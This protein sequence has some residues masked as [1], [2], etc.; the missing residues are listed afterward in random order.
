[1]SLP[2]SISPSAAMPLLVVG[3]GLTGWSVVR[4]LVAAGKEVEVTDSR[5]NPPYLAQLQLEYPQ[6]RFIPKIDELDFSSYEQIIASPGIA[7]DGDNI[8]GD[9]ELFAQEVQEPV[10]V[11]TGTNGKSTVTMLVTKML[12]AGGYVVHM[13]G[14]IGVPAL[15][16]LL[17]PQ[18][19]FY[20]LETSSFQLETTSSLS[21]ASAVVLNISEDHLD[22]Y[23]DIDDYANAKFRLYE[24]T[25]TCV[26]NRDDERV[27][28][29]SQRPGAI[30]FG[31]DA[32]CDDAFGLVENGGKQFVAFGENHLFDASELKLPGQQNVSNVLAAM[33]LIVG[34]GVT[35]SEEMIA[36]GKSYQGLPHRCERVGTWDGVTWINDSKGTNVGATL[37]AVKGCDKPSILIAGG[38]GKGADFHALAQG[39]D[40]GVKKVI[41]FGEDGPKICE[42]LLVAGV[43]KDKI[44]QGDDLQQ[45]IALAASSVAPGDTVLFSPACAS[46]D[47]FKNFEQR[48]EAFAQLVLERHHAS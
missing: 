44:Q 26:I 18:P 34:A 48:G 35:I 2:L 14:N 47:Q 19:D 29:Y 27:V 15:D 30:S 24:Q 39:I 4:H 33:A 37:A 9:I 32:P 13:G 17:L 28:A 1:M 23:V 16:L 31:L 3:L 38:Q 45:A 5:D 41:L 25:K 20:V 12:Q 7:I 42:A 6:V 11:I 43:Q 36:A 8:I 46:F 10:I 21:A 40:G 22:R